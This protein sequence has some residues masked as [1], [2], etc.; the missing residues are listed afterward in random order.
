[1]N[2]Y[3]FGPVPYPLHKFHLLVG[4]AARELKWNLKAPDALIGM[5]LLATMSASCQSLIDVKLPTGQIRPVSLNIMTIAESGE[6][7]TTVD[8]L[9]GQPLYDHDDV[10]LEQYE[11]DV[12]CYEKA[13]LLWEDTRRA[14]HKKR[15]KLISQGKCIDDI[16]MTLDEHQAHEPLQPRRRQVVRTDMTGRAFADALQGESE[17]IAIMSDEGDIL[18]RSDAMRQL[19][20]LNAA[21]DGASL[22]LDR[23]EGKS[24]LAR[25]PRVTLSIRTQPAVIREYLERKGEHARGS[26]HFARYL[27]GWP[28]TT[29]GSRFL[30]TVEPDWDALNRFHRRVEDLLK[31]RADQVRGGMMGR[32]TMEFTDEAKAEWIKLANETE[33][34]LHHQGRLHD[35]ADFGSKACEIVGRVAAVLHYFSMQ[36]GSIDADT[37]DR[38]I[39][40]VGWHLDEF[41]RLFSDGSEVSIAHADAQLLARYLHEH[42][43]QAGGNYMR[44]N[45]LLSVG[46][47]RLRK[48]RRLDPA[49]DVLIAS[50]AVWISQDQSKKRF[51]NLVSGFFAGYRGY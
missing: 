50:Q 36:D 7:K 2:T 3:N 16:N 48:K 24:V 40:I 8:R 44:R 23:A 18:L 15:S 30:N 29:Q 14:L 1:M 10:L 45:D 46:P 35:I 6:R 37:L 17:A 28:A 12:A 19:G 20:M 33:S 49:L 25:N 42:V 9:V 5:S 21:W 47:V 13:Y 26:G 38:A 41:K 11:K 31:T 43:W 32:V 27:V 34:D 22:K 51:V 39:A 4:D